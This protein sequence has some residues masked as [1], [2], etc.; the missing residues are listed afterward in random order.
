VRIRASV[1]RRQ[2]CELLGIEYGFLG[3]PDSALG[4][5]LRGEDSAVIGKVEFAIPGTSDIK[6]RMPER[7]IE[8]TPF[9]IG[10]SR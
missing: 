3:A 6:K 7:F 2:G 1:E 10:V 8:N 4:L 5:C 9:R